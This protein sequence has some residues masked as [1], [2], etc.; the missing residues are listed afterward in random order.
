MIRRL[1]AL[2]LSLGLVLAACNGAPSGDTGT[3]GTTST[4]ATAPEGVLLNYSLAAG[5]RYTFEVDLDQSLEMTTSG[6]ASAL[7]EDDMP[8]AMSLRISGTATFTYGIAAGPEEGTFEVTITGDFSAVTFDGTVD[9][10]PVDPDDVPDLAQLE[11]VDITIV[12][13]GQG[14]LIT[15]DSGGFDDPFGFFGGMDSLS[16]MGLDF[17]TFFGPPFDTSEVTVGDTWSV[18]LEIPGMGS[19]ALTGEIRSTVTGT[20]TIDGAFVFVI[21]TRTTTP[22]IEFDLAEM[23]IG[24]FEVFLQLGNPSEEELAEFY[25][26]M[27]QIRFAF[28]VAPSTIDTR[29]WFDQGAGV[30]RRSE[31]TGGTTI[32]FD[33]AIPNEE[34]GEMLE[35]GLV[36]TVDQTVGYRLVDFTGA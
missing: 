25:G 34:T 13:D 18:P 19:E 17:A 3:S 27:E 28:S 21:D 7:G 12:V 22:L 6:D 4:T 15:D 14:N 29:T 11:P 23:I 9:G 2:V 36:L 24:M 33:V 16:G 30:T 5:Q 8:G 35:F 26:I 32:S 20:D 31:M 10:E 1:S